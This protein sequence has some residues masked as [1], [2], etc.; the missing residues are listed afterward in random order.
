MKIL[1]LNNDNK[2]L[3][4]LRSKDP[5]FSE[6]VDTIGDLAIVIEDDRF[7][8]LVRFIVGQL[9]GIKAAIT[10]N[11]RLGEVLNKDISPE[12]I[13]CASTDVLRTSGISK[14][15]V[16]YIK[17]LSEKTISSEVDLL[18]M[19]NLDNNE[20]IKRLTKIKGVG[21]WTAEMFLIFALG[22]TDV[23]PQSDVSI[24]RATKWLYGY[25]GKVKGLNAVHRESEKWEPEY[26]IVCFYLWEAVNRGFV[27]SYSGLSELNI[28]F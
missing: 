21:I 16:T 8:T 6:L 12:N 24:Q 7:S 2:K 18:E 26:T 4:Y 22:R 15:K 19:D 3:Q 10:I 14:Q 11:N 27:D 25:D 17:D 20:V 9:L 1:E 28:K 23:L 13:L 5:T